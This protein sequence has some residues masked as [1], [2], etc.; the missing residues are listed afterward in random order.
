MCACVFLCARGKMHVVNVISRRAAKDGEETM[1]E[2]AVT[3]GRRGEQPM[4]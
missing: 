3:H 4:R 1:R 2:G